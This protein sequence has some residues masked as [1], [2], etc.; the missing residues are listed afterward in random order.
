M[1]YHKVLSLTSTKVIE[2]ECVIDIGASSFH[3]TPHGEFFETF[4][5]GDFSKVFLAD[6]KSPNNVCKA[7][8]LLKLSNGN[9]WLL[10]DI[11]YVTQLNNNSISFG[12]L[13]SE[14]F[15]VALESNQWKVTKES[16]LIS[17][18]SKVDSLY[19][20]ETTDE[21]G[22]TCYDSMK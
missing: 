17:R 16:L 6:Y 9:S 8:A 4:G 13:F 10:Q 3:I 18:V 11:K 5:S 2:N 7:D 21:I 19:L 22:A 1:E 15:N 20:V 12:Q 14:F